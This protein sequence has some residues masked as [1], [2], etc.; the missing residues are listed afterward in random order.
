VGIRVE[1]PFVVNA[2]LKQVGAAFSA[3]RHHVKVAVFECKC[4]KRFVT[5]LRLVKT[6]VTKTCRNCNPKK[7]A[8]DTANKKRSRAYIAWMNM[9]QRCL[10]PKNRDYANYGG[11]GITVCIEWGSFK[12]FEFDMGQ[13]SRGL[14]LDRI[15]NDR[16]YSKENCRWAT[17]HQ[18]NQNK[19]IRKIQQVDSRK[20][21]RKAQVRPMITLTHEGKTL[22]ISE[23]SKATG[24]YD[25]TIYY[26]FKKGW[27]AD[28]CL[29]AKDYRL[30]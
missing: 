17:G 9:R 5:M 23:W 22:T 1:D 10:N 4:G 27:P 29:A 16:G 12:Q 21:R 18:Q 11:R 15:N 14:S 3:T 25:R 7:H 8:D 30:S 26:R 20:V 28:R 2:D 6:G 24:V 13:P 19:R